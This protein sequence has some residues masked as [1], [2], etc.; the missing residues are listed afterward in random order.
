MAARGIRPPFAWLGRYSVLGSLIAVIAVGLFFRFYQLNSLPPGLYETSAQLGLQAQA[1]LDHG[2]LPGLDAANSYAPLFTLL[3][4]VAIKLF[5]HTALALRL[6]AALLGSLAVLTTWLWARA[7]FGARIGWLTAFL[8]AV[9]P[10]AVTLSRNDLP[11]AI[12][13]LLVTLTL[14]LGTRA[15]RA[16]TTRDYLALGAAL[17]LDLL[18]GPLGWL[19]AAGVIGTG[20]AQLARQHRLMGLGRARAAGVAGLAVGLATT[21]YLVAVSLEPLKSLPRATGLTASL[22]TLGSNLV[23]TLLMFNVRGDENYRHN[24]SGEPLLNVFVG[25]MFITGVLV[26]ISRL[27]ERRYR[28]LFALLIVL[29]IPAVITTVG[30]PNAARAV[31]ALPLVL[32]FAAA[33]ISYMLEL[34]YATFPINSAARATGQAAIIVLLALTLFQGYTQYFQAWAGSSQVYVAYNEPAVQIARHLQ[35][36]PEKKFTG[37]RYVV[38]SPSEQPVVNY[39]NHGAVPYQALQPRELAGLP[40]AQTAREFLI[41]T[42]S[43][44]DAVKTLKVKFPGGILRPHYSDF[45]QT[46]IYYSYEVAK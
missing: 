11:A 14:W 41:T 24:L 18:S 19:L 3:Q 44:D 38:A 40:V 27:H 30:V 13:P 39:L 22:S 16:G 2:T 29:M 9:T 33:G 5:G 21:S 34:W 6:W 37:Q 26:G 25:I 42:G 31:A 7:W 23:K 10:W 43:R 45:N 17:S 15:W 4:A 12:M 35:T 1:L 20:I 8:V 36:A 32:A 46:E 28:L